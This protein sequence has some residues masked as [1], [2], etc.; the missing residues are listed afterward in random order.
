[1]RSASRRFVYRNTPGSHLH[2]HARAATISA[3][4]SASVYTTDPTG[5]VRGWRGRRNSSS[6]TLG[7]HSHTDGWSLKNTY[8][9]TFL[10][11]GGNVP[12]RRWRPNPHDDANAHADQAAAA[13]TTS[14]SSHRLVLSAARSRMP[15]SSG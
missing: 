5:C 13:A 6:A 2:L 8:I 7:S 14:R 3:L 1:M 9:F 12:C 10:S 4:S 11:Q 15:S